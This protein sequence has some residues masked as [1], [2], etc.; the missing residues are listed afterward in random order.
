[1]YSGVGKSGSPAPKPITGRPAALSAFALLS[2]A[3]VADS[4]MAPMRAEILE[5]MTSILAPTRAVRGPG[6]R[7]GVWSVGIR[8]RLYGSDRGA[9]PGAGSCGQDQVGGC[10]E[11]EFDQVAPSP[12]TLLVRALMALIRHA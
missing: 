3:S 10:R 8:W 7:R 11:A 4:L 5:A 9:T 6:N 12:Y 2:T 1:M